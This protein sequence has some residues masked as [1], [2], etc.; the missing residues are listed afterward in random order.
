MDTFAVE[1]QQYSV[2][3]A[4]GLPDEWDTMSL[5]ERIDFLFSEQ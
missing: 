2:R 3:P 5:D 4:E 1:S